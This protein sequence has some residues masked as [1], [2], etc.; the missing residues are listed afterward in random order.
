MTKKFNV[1]KIQTETPAIP[2]EIGELKFDFDTSD[3]S[4]KRFH[5]GLEQMQKELSEL[6]IAGLGELEASKQ[7]LRTG[8]DFM[9]GEG[10]FDKIYEQTP[11][12]ISCMKYFQQLSTGIKEHLD[13]VG[14]VETQ[15]EKA[16]KYVS[17][18][19]K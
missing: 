14:L 10:T 2:V 12:V 5:E 9:L 7:A 17:S 6:D 3:E 15:A 4:I 18:K 16:K 1:I 8:Y 13:E 11:S 19:K